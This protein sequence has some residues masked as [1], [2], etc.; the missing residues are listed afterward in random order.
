MEEEINVYIAGINCSYEDAIR[1]ASKGSK[2]VILYDLE[3]T[4]NKRPC[5]DLVNFS[6]Y[7]ANDFFTMI[8]NMV[9]GGADMIV[10][11]V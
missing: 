8:D 11:C 10:N 9:G 3:E 5:I 4:E 6:E 2:V 1:E 7:E